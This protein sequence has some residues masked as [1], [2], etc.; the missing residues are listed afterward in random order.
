MERPALDDVFYHL[1]TAANSIE[2]EAGSIKTRIED[3]LYSNIDMLY[4]TYTC[5]RTL[6]PKV[7]KVS[8]NPRYSP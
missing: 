4:P 5:L 3:M 2:A 8:P 1:S 6:Y 7:P